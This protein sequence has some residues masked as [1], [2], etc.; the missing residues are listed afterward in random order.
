MLRERALVFFIRHP[1]AVCTYSSRAFRPF[2]A[3]TFSREKISVTMLVHCDA[4]SYVGESRKSCRAA[5]LD[6]AR[7]TRARCASPR[8]HASRT[9]GVVVR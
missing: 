4:L 8:S 6:V 3:A 2:P 7:E 5:A 1:S 9:G